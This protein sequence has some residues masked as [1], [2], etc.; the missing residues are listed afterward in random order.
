MRASLL[1]YTPNAEE[2]VAIAAKIC[3]SSLPIHSITTG[4]DTAEFLQKLRTMGHLS[5][6]EH[7]SFTFLISGISRACSHQLIRHRIASYSQRSQRY[8]QDTNPEFIEPESISKS[9]QSTT[10]KVAL[11]LAYGHYLQLISEGVPEEDARFVLPNACDTQLMM[12]MNARE[13]IHFCQTR[14]CNRAQ[15]EI[16]KLA[17]L[18]AGA[19][20]KECPNLFRGITVPPCLYDNSCPEGP[21]RCKTPVPDEIRAFL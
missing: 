15:W 4:E 17:T 9:K 19:I 7:V 5:P 12:T 1:T 14:L 18:I 2:V 13:L 3:Y 10:Y 11:K 8:V 20:I 6:F 21:F 16:R